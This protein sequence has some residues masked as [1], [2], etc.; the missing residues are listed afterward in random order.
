MRR[1]EFLIG[2]AL[3][4]AG[5]PVAAWRREESR[6]GWRAGVAA[7]DITPEPGIWMAG[8]A[9]R[10]EAAQGTELP[11][12]AK[13][14][15]LEDDAGRRAV[16]V[17]LDLLGVTAAM[18][19]RI[20][21][22]LERRASIPS[23][24]L[25]LASSHTHSG[26]VVREQ[27]FIAYGLDRVQ[28]E[29]ITAYTSWLEE[30]V[31]ETAVK[32]LGALEPCEITLGETRATFAANRRTAFVPPG[33]VDHTVPVL[34]MTG[35][36]GRTRA[37]VF[38]YACHNTTLPP[39]MVRF[40]GDYA[41]V[42]QR[43][44]EA[45]NPGA[46]AFF[47]AG[48]GADANPG[49]RGTLELVEQHGRALASAV[50]DALPR[51]Q[52]IGTGLATSLEWIALP[53]APAPGESHWRAKLQDDDVYVRRHAQLMLDRLAA[54][55]FENAHEEPIQ[56]WRLGD[57]RLVALGGEVVVDYLLRIR[58][59]NPGPLWV[60]GYANDVSCYVPS[61]RVLREGGYEGGGAMLY[62]GRPGPFDETVEE[63]IVAAVRRGLERCVAG[64]ASA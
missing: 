25:M 20:T 29:R 33:P 44:I 16:L 5:A 56:V 57:W 21:T 18:R 47:I 35:A 60:A 32:A 42:A 13:A 50:N 26:P 64:P 10:K 51:T 23:A 59:E 63:R 24:S 40:H 27:L 17:T 62:Y 3:A 45:A 55:T 53:F 7:T 19:R 46:T 54:G 43:E 9:A 15:A 30:A 48:C 12:F 36:N 39:T 2:S 61:L 1:R 22:A 28:R 6:F 52:P 41:G 14:L 58:R 37:V 11:L 31:V 49:P 8:Y 38:G 34:R 4:L